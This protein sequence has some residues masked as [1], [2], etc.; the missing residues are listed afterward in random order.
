MKYIKIKNNGLME[1][2]AL[3]LVG[4]S[5]KRNDSSKIGM[6]GSGNKYALAYFLRNHHEVRIF[7]GQKEI[8]VTTIAEK[9]RDQEFHVLHVDG[10]KTSIT[11]DMGKDWQF[12]QAMREIY[13]N[14]IDEGGAVMEMV[15][16]V[17]PKDNETHWYIDTKKDVSEFVT[18]H[19]QYFATNKKVLFECEFGRILEKSGEIANIYRK[20]IRCFET[21]KKSVYD[22]DFANIDIDE[23][24]L[25]KYFWQTEGKMWNL[26]YRCT[27]KEVIMSILHNSSNHDFIEGCLSD[28]CDIHTSGISPEFIE[29]LKELRLAPSGFAGLLKPE[30]VHN[31]VILPT[32][33]FNSVRGYIPEQNVMAAFKVTLKGDMYR[34][35]E[36]NE[37]QKQTIK[38]ALYFLQECQQEMPYEIKVAIFD[39]KN[40]YGC[41]IDGVIWLSDTGLER[42]V[43]ECVNTI[44]EEYVHI[45][46]DVKDETRGFQTA[47]ITEFISYMKKLN[48]FAI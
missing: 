24:R 8:T 31:H 7:A 26:I 9:F 25:V 40:I 34:E 33:V 37:L 15:Q 19:D 38:D 27:N 11:I 12:W 18:K 36:P 16:K 6:F 39:E 23:N 41:A 5:T 3:H 10:V 20:G 32:K 44:L 30:E 21:N 17:D 29:C 13:C 45:K 1:P 4:A 22:Y 28:Y 14:A 47:M 48:S 35:I 46:Y 42:G 2:Q 43:N